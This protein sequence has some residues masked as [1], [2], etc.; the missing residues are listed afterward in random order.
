LNAYDVNEDRKIDM[1]TDESLVHES[2][3]F[4]DEISIENQ[5]RNLSPG[6]DQ[7]PTEVIQAGSTTL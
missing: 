4:K 1:N 3:S 6:T 2:S 7:I 5:K